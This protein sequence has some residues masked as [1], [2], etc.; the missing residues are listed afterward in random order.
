MAEDRVTV[1]ITDAV[2]DVRLNRPE[3]RNALDQAMFA[4]LVS[5]GER[6]RSE[7]GLRAVVLSGAGPDFCAGLDFGSARA[8]LPPR[9]PSAPQPP[10]LHPVDFRPPG[11]LTRPDVVPPVS[12]SGVDDRTVDVGP[13]H[14]PGPQTGPPSP[15]SRRIRSWCR[16]TSSG[17]PSPSPMA[18]GP[19]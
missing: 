7:P 5:T 18:S 11:L 17:S 16:P 10:A 8:S 3:K 2:A 19:L 15:A 13:G 9:R 4:G 1:T 6:L 14:A 12:T